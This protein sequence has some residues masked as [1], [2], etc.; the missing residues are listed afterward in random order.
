MPSSNS[1]TFSTE[2]SSAASFTTDTDGGSNLVTVAKIEHE[3]CKIY[4]DVNVLND[5]A[6]DIDLTSY[7]SKA[8]VYYLKAKMAEDGRDM[9]GR[10]YFMRLFKK[11]LEKERS[12]RKRGPYVAMGNANMRNY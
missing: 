8:I 11:Q 2:E 1:T 7:Q 3:V 6:D 9:E 4:T 10:E 5:E 12:A